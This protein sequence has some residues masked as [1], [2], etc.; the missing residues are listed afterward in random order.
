MHRLNPRRARRIQDKMM[1][2][3]GINLQEMDEVE[4]VVFNTPTKDIII[5]DA[6]VTVVEMQGRKMYQVIGEK[7]REVPRERKIEIPREDAQLVADQTGKSL[8]EAEEA[9]R[10]TDGDLARA[11]LMLQTK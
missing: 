1:K 6:R 11:I 5:E 8:A 2:D 10:E 3:M 7:I 9:L 4:R